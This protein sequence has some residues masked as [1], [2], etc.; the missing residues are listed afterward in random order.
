M[1]TQGGG[2]LG[3]SRTPTTPK[4]DDDSGKQTHSGRNDD[5][6]KNTES[7]KKP[8]KTKPKDTG[9]GKIDCGPRPTREDYTTTKSYFDDDKYERAQERYREAYAQWEQQSEAYD[10]WMNS[11]ARQELERYREIRGKLEEKRNELAESEMVDG[12][13]VR[14][15]TLGVMRDAL[16][17]LDGLETEL[18]NL[19]P[20]DNVSMPESALYASGSTLVGLSSAFEQIMYEREKIVAGGLN[21]A[22][23]SL[24]NSISAQRE[25]INFIQQSQAIEEAAIQQRNNNILSFVF[26][27]ALRFIPV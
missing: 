9:G 15:E 21:N 20:Q 3:D 10:N 26:N 24:R 13:Y 1:I 6:G 18:E 25:G 23:T 19:I 27:T 11:D 5:S 12:K 7:G 2:G 16:D 22:Y 4:D 14:E 17:E 8:D